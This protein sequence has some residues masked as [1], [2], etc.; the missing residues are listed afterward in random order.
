MNQEARQEKDKE[1][2]Q[3][4]YAHYFLNKVGVCEH[5]PLG[6]LN[7]EH[8][9]YV[10]GIGFLISYLD[11]AEDIYKTSGSHRAVQKILDRVSLYH[12]DVEE[13]MPRHEGGV[14]LRTKNGDEDIST[15]AKTAM[16]DVHKRM[17]DIEELLASGGKINKKRINGYPAGQDGGQES[18][19]VIYS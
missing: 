8:S 19:G 13:A 2:F 4:K 6:K 11:K 12:P 17:D 5:Q 9:A 7:G 10:A 18:P 1:M 3:E 15:L 14:K 16:N